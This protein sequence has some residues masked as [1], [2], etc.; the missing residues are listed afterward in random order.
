MHLEH[1]VRVLRA[2]RVLGHALGQADRARERPEAPLKP[3]VAPLFGSH[4]ALAFGS[5][6]EGAV[7]ELD[8]AL[9]LGDAGQ[10]ERV[11]ELAL[12]LPDSVPRDP[13]RGRAPVAL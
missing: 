13:A 10:G 12:G 6:R 2:D 3:E 5:D 8:G 7:L 9:L 1:A 11:D 4:L